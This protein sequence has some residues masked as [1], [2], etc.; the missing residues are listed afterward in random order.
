MTSLKN[1]GFGPSTK[2]DPTCGGQYE[3]DV[4]DGKATGRGV[5]IWPQGDRY[6]GDCVDGK[7]HGRGVMTSPND[8]YRYEGDFVNGKFHGRGVLTV[9]EDFRY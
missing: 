8:R 9:P 1:G 6:E 3:G 4:V 2:L 7:R 5:I